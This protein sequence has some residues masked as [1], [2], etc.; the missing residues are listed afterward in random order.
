MC[1][2]NGTGA[3]THTLPDGEC[4]G[5]QKPASQESC[6]LRRCQKQRKLQWFVSQWQQ[7][8]SLVKMGRDSGYVLSFVLKKNSVLFLVFSVQQ[9]VA[10]DIRLASSN[11]QRRSALF[12]L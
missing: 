5:L 10:V 12:I 9:R 3:Q 8:N 4:A 7:V 1:S 6:F 11:V 2:S